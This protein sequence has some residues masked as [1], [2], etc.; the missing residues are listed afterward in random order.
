[1]N[2]FKS[3]FSW[4]MNGLTAS[5]AP[6]IGIGR[7]RATF[8]LME[9][10]KGYDCYRRKRARTVKSGTLLFA[11][12]SKGSLIRK[13]RAK[14][15]ELRLASD[16][17]I[18]RTIQLPA[19]GQDYL[20]PI[21]RHQLERLTPWTP[22]RVVFGYTVADEPD[23]EDGQ[24]ALSLVATAKDILDE[25]I[26]GLRSLG[27]KVVAVGTTAD[28]ADQ[29]MRI[30]L[31]GDSAMERFAGLRRRVAVVVGVLLAIVAGLGAYTEWTVSSM[32]QQIAELDRRIMVRRR[33]IAAAAG[34]LTTSDQDK[35]LIDRK[36]RRMPAVVLVDHISALLPQNTFLT[37]LSVEGDEV[38]LSGISDEASTLIALIE[39]S[40]Q[41]AG[42]R[43]TAP[44]TRDRDSGRDN[45][46]ILAK[47]EKPKEPGS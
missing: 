28:P 26:D 21:I 47:V 39:G 46:R 7:S 24:I 31:L 38:R 3:F 13:L 4:W 30:D 2:V 41:F 14:P 9:T 23:R 44:T 1:M 22:D 6:H 11:G 16:K 43:F 42:A 15:V 45:F 20:D 25:A 27:I 32:D 29:P 33:Q 19:A 12:R 35:T 36:G 37:E 17:L 8:V 10:D 5:L 34:E 18:N 40:E